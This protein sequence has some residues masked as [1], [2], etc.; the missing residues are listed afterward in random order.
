MVL[1]EWARAA[2]QI[3]LTPATASGSAVRVDC[4]LNAPLHGK[5][6]EY[7]S[8]SQYCP[9]ADRRR[10]TRKSGEATGGV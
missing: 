6:S 10:P 7:H 1:R 5:V 3:A 2:L 4:V 8:Q 9:R